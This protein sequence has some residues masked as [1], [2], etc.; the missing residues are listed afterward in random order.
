MFRELAAGSVKPH[1]EGRRGTAQ[2]RG[3]VRHIEVLPGGEPEDLSLSLAE[4]RQGGNDRIALADDIRG[5]TSG[6]PGGL[7]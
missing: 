1:P 5:V 6:P 7:G 2:H 4:P 3:R